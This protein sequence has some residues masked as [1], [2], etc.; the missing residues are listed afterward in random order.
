MN[1]I[2]AIGISFRDV[3]SAVRARAALP[4]EEDT[5]R[6]LRQQGLTGVVA[7][8]TCAR[9]LWIVSAENAEWTAALLQTMVARR[10][11]AG[12]GPVLPHLWTGRLALHYALRVSVG[13]DSHVQGEADIGRQVS[14]AF[15]QAH[16][17]GNADGPLHLLQQSVHRLLARGRSMG[18]IRPNRGL[19][20]LAV[21]ALDRAGLPHQATVGVIGTG[22]IGRRVMAS[23]QRAGRP[24]VL[25]NRSESA[26]SLPLSSL[27]EHRL[28]AMVVC[29]A[30]PAGWLRPPPGSL[31]VD[32][33]LPAQVS[34]EIPSLGIDQLLEGD[35]LRLPAER[36]ELAE[37]VV[38]QEV[39]VLLLRLSASAQQR[40]LSRLNEARDRFLEQSLPELLAPSLGSLAEEDR[41]RV[42]AAVKGLLRQYSHSLLTTLKED[43]SQMENP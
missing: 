37:Q 1:Q 23:L 17:E 12:P 28:D 14:S 38:D 25:F 3:P 20:Q 34:P 11:N 35:T 19:G 9:S 8:H 32:L 41:R 42:Q 5:L 13:L 6:Q 40:R 7:V 15:A 4:L 24:Y 21:E 18:F 26:N 16:A 10:L 2:A 22:A 39:E 33:G 29:T 36:V 27:S 43:F 31:V 30:G